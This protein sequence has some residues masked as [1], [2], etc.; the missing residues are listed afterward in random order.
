MIQELQ[1]EN[2]TQDGWDLLYRDFVE[3]ENF[4]NV[5]ENYYVIEKVGSSV[6]YWVD[7]DQ[8]VKIKLKALHDKFCSK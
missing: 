8:T 4:R 6:T 7:K 5:V 3:C 2:I 1:A